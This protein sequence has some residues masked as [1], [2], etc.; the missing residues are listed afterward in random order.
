MKLK[1][2]GVG[3]EG[4][5][6]KPR[7]FDRA[8]ALLDP[9]LAGSALVVESD[10]ILGRSRHVGDD[11]DDARIKLARMPFHLRDHPA[12]LRPASGLIMEIG[13]VSA[14]MVRRTTDR[15]GEQIADPFLQDLVRRKPD[16]VSDPFGFKILV[17]IGIG[18]ARVGEKMDARDPSAISRHDRLKHIPPSV[19]A[20]DDA[21]TQRATFQVAELIEHEQRMIAGALV[22]PVPD[23]VLLFAMGRTDA[24]IHVEQNASRRTPG[25]NAVDP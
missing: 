16:R 7:P 1:A 10:D 25:M 6:G 18:E 22:V 13:V 24:R 19:G 17:D 12:W 23:A 11:V 20:V 3:G 2:H 14:H 4:T 21:G 8:L 15:A 5:A 9:L